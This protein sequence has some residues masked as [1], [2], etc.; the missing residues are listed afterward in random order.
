MFTSNLEIAMYEGATIWTTSGIQGKVNKAAEK[1]AIHRLRRKHGQ[2]RGGIAKC[3][4]EHR[5]RTSDIISMPVWTQV[6]VPRFFYPLTTATDHVWPCT[7]TRKYSNFYGSIN[8]TTLTIV[9]S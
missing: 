7:E 8:K 5:I 3:T 6:E 2:V 4:F 1:K 9:S